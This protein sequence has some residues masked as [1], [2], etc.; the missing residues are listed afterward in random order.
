MRHT[1][2]FTGSKAGFE[3]NV[4]ISPRL[5]AIPRLKRNPF[6]FPMNPKLEGKEMIENT[7]DSTE[8]FDVF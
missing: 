6:C 5:V 4:F 7:L 3:F 2:Y 8:L 1:V